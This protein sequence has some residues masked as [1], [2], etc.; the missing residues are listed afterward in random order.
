LKRR[1]ARMH[2]SA[3]R[4]YQETLNEV[5]AKSLPTTALAEAAVAIS[6]YSLPEQLL[7][8]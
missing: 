5:A 2:H 1:D 3:N 8:W 4:I 7:S 6:N